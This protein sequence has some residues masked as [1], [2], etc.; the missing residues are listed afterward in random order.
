MDTP[1]RWSFTMTVWKGVVTSES[2]SAAPLP[3]TPRVCTVRSSRQTATINSRSAYFRNL[4]DGPQ[5][6]DRGL[7]R[8]R[9]LLEEI[10]LVQDLAGAEGHAGQRIV[11]N[12][13]G[14]V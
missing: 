14:E 8:D 7:R 1:A 9:D 4:T 6:R 5:G 3:L 12:G 13:D 2:A 11:A 10:H